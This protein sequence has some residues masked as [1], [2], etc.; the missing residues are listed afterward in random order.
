[1]FKDKLY[2]NII[3]CYLMVCG[4]A[5]HFL[6][7]FMFLDDAVSSGVYGSMIGI[8][9]GTITRFFKMIDKILL[10]LGNT[11]ET[12]IKL[13]SSSAIGALVIGV[14]LTELVRWFFTRKRK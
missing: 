7:P 10:F 8:I 5:T 1:M 11:I 9:G 2:F 6:I 3:A 12:I 14:I 4:V 13:D